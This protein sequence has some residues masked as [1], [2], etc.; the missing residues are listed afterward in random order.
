MPVFKLF[1]L[2][3][4][5][6]ALSLIIYAGIFMV[7][8]TLLTSNGEQAKGAFKES[9]TSVGIVDLDKSD[10]S[11][12]LISYLESKHH[13]KV[14]EKDT[15][16]MAEEL[17][18]YIY[19]VIIEIPE[20]L[21]KSMLTGDGK[22]IIMYDTPDSSSQAYVF[23]QVNQ[24]LT[25][26]TAYAKMGFTG[27][28]LLSKTADN[29]E[30]EAEVK[31]QGDGVSTLNGLPMYFQMLS[32]IMVAALVATITPVIV[33]TQEKGLAAR[34][35]CSSLPK[36]KQ[37]MGL[38]AGT[39]IFSIIFFVVFLMV[40]Y[41]GFG[42]NIGENSW[43]YIVN[44]FVFLLFVV[45]LVFLVS[46]FQVSKN[47][48]SMISN[49]AGLGLAFLGGVFVEIELLSEEVLVVSKCLPTYWYMNAHGIITSSAKTLQISDI[50]FP[51]GMQLLFA[52]TLLAVA[53]VVRQIKRSL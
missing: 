27:E 33:A 42:Q 24:Y 9:K 8:L 50:A 39:V 45:G 43:L 26:Y 21:E 14:V 18:Y 46:S 23:R 49:V 44:A 6:N 32:Y 47:A 5:R 41:V 28:E 17:Y 3:V 1:F 16:R 31:M 52:V 22:N 36:I 15:E 35:L 51:L 29:M 13:V 30:V 48:I 20:G 37:N 7:L 10:L 38:F 12:S 25:S 2:L 53:L 40:G 19:E 11:E 34:N 4:K